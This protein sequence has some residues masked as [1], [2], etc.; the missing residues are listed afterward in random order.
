MSEIKLIQSLD[1]LLNITFKPVK[2]ETIMNVSSRCSYALNDNQEVIGL[3]LHNCKLN[4]LSF[5]KPFKQLIKLNL[6]S[7]KI[8][9]ISALKTHTLLQE[10]N[11][12]KNTITDIHSLKNLLQLQE[13]NLQANSIVDIK[14]FEKTINLIVLNLSSNKI[15]NLIFLSKLLALKKLNL[16]DNKLT[17]LTGINKLTNINELDLRF[18]KLKSL[19]EING[20][21]KL[22]TLFIN[23]NKVT[24]ITALNNLITLESFHASFN[25]IYNLSPLN[26]LINL[27]ILDL[28][29][30]K[31]QDIN[32]LKSLT[33]LTHLYLE[34]NSINNIQALEKSKKLVQLNLR[35]NQIIDINAL[36]GCKSL[37]HLYLSK[38]K[39]EKLP[40]WLIELNLPIKLN[41]GGEGI[42]VI[43]NPI[44][45]PPID[46]IQRGNLVIKDYY[47]QLTQQ[48]KSSVKHLKIHIIGGQ[49]VGK[50]S[51]IKALKGEEFNSNEVNTN[52]ISIHHWQHEDIKLNCWDFSGKN[53][54]QT[55]N[56]AFFLPR[57]VYLLVL[58]QNSQAMQWLV[59]I[60]NIN[61]KLPIFIILNKS[62]SLKQ[63]TLDY[64]FL[65]NRFP[66][67]IGYYSVSCL[68][69]TGIEDFKLALYKVLKKT[70][71]VN[72]QISANEI[73]LK[74]AL[75]EKLFI[76]YLDGI[77]LCNE[78]GITDSKAQLQFINLLI[79]FGDIVYISPA[80]KQQENA[81]ICNPTWI[82]KSLSKL[83]NNDATEANGN[84]SLNEI[85]QILSDSTI[86][87]IN[88]IIKIM[89][90]LSLA[91]QINDNNFL[92]P[93][94][95]QNS[96][97]EISFDDVNAL[98]IE[99]QFNYLT[100]LIMSRLIIALY[101]EIMPTFCYANQIKLE[102]SEFKSC[103]VI[104]AN[105]AANLISIKTLG[106]KNRAYYIYLRD[107]LYQIN[108]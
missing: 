104:T 30:N 37:T 84:I 50:T 53:T 52:G 18:N 68:R 5:I 41:N 90:Q 64:K 44:K 13:L 48:K 86:E 77:S 6:S 66:N 100:P 24:D 3:N 31:V 92:I 73:L 43:E 57:S 26:N 78:H 2:L 16:S 22:S 103:A 105:Y 62:D 95:L 47:K 35:N 76:N 46:V 108:P 61:P 11:L 79:Y 17:N 69:K 89:L 55:L 59:R 63:H 70:P 71:S 88:C 65:N 74:H 51:F 101:T 54:L 83:F 49:G 7:N 9:D 40:E 33:N 60:E 20:I 99:I 72:L 10:L 67:I 28:R 106:E 39:I 107:M 94:L 21:L 42:S 102:N 93:A 97:N 23:N 19:Q 87:D 80:N 1:K 85:K 38:N 32:T 36:I 45:F 15:S 98:K 75:E 8:T 58:D 4:T 81:I 34:S 14:V 12:Q 56:Q 91:Y 82:T 27:K 29:V 25:E 96:T